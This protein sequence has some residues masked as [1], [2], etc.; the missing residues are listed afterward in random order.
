MEELPDLDRLSHADKD[1]LPRALFAEVKALTAQVD[2]LTAKEAD[3][4]GR[5]AKNSRNSGKPPSSDVFRP[6]ARR[7]GCELVGNVVLVGDVVLADEYIFDVRLHRGW[8]LEFHF[9]LVRFRGWIG[10]WSRRG[11]PDSTGGAE[12]SQ[13]VGMGASIC[14]RAAGGRQQSWSSSAA[15]GEPCGYAQGVLPH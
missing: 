14:I 15:F 9:S 4:E 7:S 8:T 13:D 6:N 12:F 11:Y 3:L 1:D 10:E 2:A 5:L